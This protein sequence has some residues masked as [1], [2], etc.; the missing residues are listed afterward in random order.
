MKFSIVGKSWSSSKQSCKKKT[1]EAKTCIIYHFIMFS[2]KQSQNDML[3]LSTS[4]KSLNIFS[5]H[6]SQCNHEQYDQSYH[7]YDKQAHYGSHELNDQIDHSYDRQVH[8]YSHEL[9]GQ[10][11][12]SY[13]RQSHQCNRELNDQ[14]DHSYG[15][16]HHWYSHE[17]NDQAYYT[18]SYI[19]INDNKIIPENRLMR[20]KRSTL[21]PI[22]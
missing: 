2:I 15:R 11:D 18:C 20:L 21:A 12:N 1:E 5:N 4:N 6:F 19:L 13:D 16:Q 10:V 7:T 3:Q 9:H 22:Q 8:Q 14:V 17:L